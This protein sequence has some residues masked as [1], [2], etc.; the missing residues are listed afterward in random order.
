MISCPVVWSNG[1][2]DTHRDPPRVPSDFDYID[3]AY[4][5]AKKNT[6]FQFEWRKKIKGTMRK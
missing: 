3:K 4:N 5:D 6:A 1:S 2:K